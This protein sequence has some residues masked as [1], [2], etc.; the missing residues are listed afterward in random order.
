MTAVQIKR[1]TS[2]PQVTHADAVAGPGSE[3]AARDVMLP[4]MARAPWA[5]AVGATQTAVYVHRLG[6]CKKTA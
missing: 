6:F 5:R 4:A 2:V 3:A 1:K